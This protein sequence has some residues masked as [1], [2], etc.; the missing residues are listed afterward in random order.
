LIG[1]L[2]TGPNNAITDVPG[3]TVGHTTLI[4][5]EPRIARTG[6]TV[7]M[8]RGGQVQN[9]NAFA[10]YYS[11]NGNGEMTGLPWLEETGLLSSPVAIT[12]T[13]QVGVVRDALVEY[14]ANRGLDSW[15]L[16]V[17]AETYDGFLND[18]NA[19]HVTKEHVFQAL[20]S[21]SDGPVAEGNV[22]GGT[23]MMCH[24]FKGGIGS[25]SRVAD[26]GGASY[27]VGT[28]VQ[29]NYGHRRL[30]RVD[31]VP[32]GR[33]INSDVVPLPGRSDDGEGSII[34]IVATDA[35]LI[36]IQ[37]KRLVQ[38]ATIGLARAGGVGHNGSGDIFLAFS[39]GNHPTL[40]SSEDDASDTGQPIDVQM[41]PNHLI[42]PLFEATAE[43]VEESILNALTAA[44]TTVGY[45]GRTAHAIPLDTLQHVMEKYQ[46]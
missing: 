43:A 33:E 27:T 14:A 39:T 32:V 23:G 17:V 35:P 13:H 41:I 34:V 10:A 36:P 42:D 5:D 28:L 2:P 46:P 6:V 4:Y 3:V 29:A 22:G 25:A 24:G 18:I 26:V 15:F 9:D 11:F 21:A 30:L 45:Q 7:V 12:N 38:R 44:E 8:P 40:D 20:D 31:G 19:F 16:P 37:C 1:E